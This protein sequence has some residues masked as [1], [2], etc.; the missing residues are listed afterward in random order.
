MKTRVPGL[1]SLIAFLSIIYFGFACHKSN[2][3]SSNPSVN[4]KKGLL[5]YLPFNASIADSS[6]NNNPTQIVGSGAGLTYDEHGYANSAYG[7]DGTGGRLEVTNNGSIQ[8]DTAFSL[9]LSFMERVVNGNQMFASMVNPATGKGPSFA[10]GTTMLSSSNVWLG[11]PRNSDCNAYGTNDAVD[12][13]TFAPQA[14]AWYNITCTFHRGTLKTYL[15]GS[16]ISQG[17]ASAFS[18]HICPDGKIIIG[19]WWDNDPLSINGKIDNVRLYN[20]ELS[21]DEIAVLAQYHQPTTNSIRQTIGS[22]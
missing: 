6:G 2:S 13:T 12:S 3:G 17:T 21:I 20:R 14:E 4:L 22:N 10:V 11:V 18:S 9:S 8:F 1:L 7:S 5:L 15:N 16:L 19:G